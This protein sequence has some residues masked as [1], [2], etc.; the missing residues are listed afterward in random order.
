[1]RVIITGAS[2]RIGSQLVEELSG[3]HE[4]RLIDVAPVKGH[5]S[6][7]GD[8]SAVPIGWRRWVKPRSGR[9]IEAFKGAQAVVHLAADGNPA[10]PWESILSNNIQGTWNVIQAAARHRVPRMVFASSNWAVKALEQELAPDCYRPDGPKIGSETA[11]RALKAY[12]LSKGFG[13]LAGRMFVDEG[14]LETFV[15]VRIGHYGPNPSANDMVRWIGTEDLR[16]LFRRCIEADLKGFHV[17][18]GVSAQTTA[19]DL[20]YTRELL[21]WFPRQVPDRQST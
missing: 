2:G 11:P 19:Y 15:A 4:L 21:S 10:A 12:G 18:Y 7:F 5:R 20:S 6:I 3:S 16:D 8:V 1:M 17:V 14:K 13:E 9:W